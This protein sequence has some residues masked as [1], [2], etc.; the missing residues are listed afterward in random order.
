MRLI[1]LGKRVFD[2]LADNGISWL[3]RE[4]M[5]TVPGHMLVGYSEEEVEKIIPI[6]KC[7]KGSVPAQKAA[8][9]KLR[10]IS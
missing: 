4:T 9:A 1:E 3:D 6:F 5:Q 8:L 2:Y 7:F 10:R